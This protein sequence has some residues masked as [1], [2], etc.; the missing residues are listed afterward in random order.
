[1]R[2]KSSVIA[3]P[4]RA[5]RRAAPRAVRKTRAIIHLNQKR[6]EGEKSTGSGAFGSDLG[7]ANV[8]A[9]VVIVTPTVVVADP[10]GVKELGFKVQL[11][12]AGGPAQVRV[13]A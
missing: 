1:M 3:I 2:T 7:P 12:F 13:R 6:V 5:R 10:F 9:V 11:E 4:N 8:R